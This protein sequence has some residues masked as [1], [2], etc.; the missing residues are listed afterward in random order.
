MS[1]GAAR[2]GD[3]AADGAGDRTDDDWMQHVNLDPAKKRSEIRRK[4]DEMREELKSTKV[5]M[6]DVIDKLI[7][8]YYAF[9]EERERLELP[10]VL[11]LHG[12]Q[13]I[14]KTT[15]LDSFVDLTGIGDEQKLTY[16]YISPG[17][18]NFPMDEIET[19]LKENALLPENQWRLIVVVLDETQN[20]TQ[21]GNTKPRLWNLLG[22]GSYQIRP[23]NTKE[24]Y[25]KGEFL[26]L[27]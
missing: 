23:R 2:G 21:W 24:D 7:D 19:K 22:T 3:G 18:Q 13:G 14:G 6:D 9:K 5:G 10:L 15:L 20:V 4:Y 12:A 25:L 16:I 26:R 8:Y 11:H 1:E 27:Y 17:G